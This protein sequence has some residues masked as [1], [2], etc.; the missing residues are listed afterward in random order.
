VREHLAAR[1]LTKQK[2]PELLYPVADLPRTPLGKVQKFRLRQ[3][4]RDGT[5]EGGVRP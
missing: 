5:F 3:E 2:W 4:I 1:R